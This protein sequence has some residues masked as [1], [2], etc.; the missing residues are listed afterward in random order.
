M[1]K[2]MKTT[3][4]ML[5]TRHRDMPIG[6]SLPSHPVHPYPPKLRQPLGLDPG[7]LIGHAVLPPVLAL[8]PRPR[9]H[10]LSDGHVDVHGVAVRDR[11]VH[12]PP[13]SPRLRSRP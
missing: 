9:P 1:P 5:G 2:V 7:R 6:F 10:P 3:H 11:L 12:R 4:Q 8:T 13:A